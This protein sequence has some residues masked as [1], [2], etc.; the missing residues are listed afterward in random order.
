MLDPRLIFVALVWGVNFAFVKFALADFSPLSFTVTRF[1]LAS[2]FLFCVMIATG[3]P[4]GID[5]KDRAAIIRL[6]FIG[7]TLYNIFFMY[8]I[9]YTTASHSALFISLS[10][11]FAVLL[12]SVGSRE[13]PTLRAGA[14]MLLASAG[15]YVIIN[16]H[17][18]GMR[19]T[20]SDITG[21][22]LTLV[23]AFFWALYT[24][25]SKP[26]LEKYSPVKITAYCMAAGSIILFPIGAY[27]LF[28][29]SW[30]AIS[31]GSWA[32]FGFST[33]LSGGV[34]FSLW[35]QGVKRI[36][37]TRTVAY[38]YLVPFIAVLF[39]AFFLG[40]R[41]TLSQM[42]GGAAIISG[43]ALVQRRTSEVRKVGS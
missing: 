35:Y 26:L 18:E 32:A 34:A 13:R 1:A 14:G 41:I 29:Q 21:D 4:L 39:A 28:D 36:G 5:R 42:A 24:I 23:A 33:I 20:T 2:L 22:L 43:V 8:G 17:G 31:A 11:L 37:V 9:K 6:G 15:V 16:S 10:P 27:E 3:E 38:H 40:E 7:I 19:F 30:T 12:Q 25:G